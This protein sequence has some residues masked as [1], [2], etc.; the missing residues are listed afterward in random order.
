M[1]GRRGMVR[2]RLG[3]RAVAAVEE[4]LHVRPADQGTM[5][6]L[7][8]RRSPSARGQVAAATAGCAADPTQAAGAR[9]WT[10][11]VLDGPARLDSNSAT[12]HAGLRGA[13]QRGV[14]AGGSAGPT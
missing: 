5:M 3:R 2:A 6:P 10:G 1:A 11:R 7:R 4:T 12:H 8:G 9:A 14:C 13:L